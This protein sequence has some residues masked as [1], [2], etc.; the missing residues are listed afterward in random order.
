[1]IRVD[2]AQCSG[3]KKIDSSR[4]SQLANFL[5]AAHRALSP[6]IRSLMANICSNSRAF[7][8]GVA[9]RSSSG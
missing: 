6:L 3:L 4:G 7:R 5:A 9:S 1:M 8:E 2:L